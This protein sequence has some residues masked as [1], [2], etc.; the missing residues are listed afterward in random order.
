MYAQVNQ[1]ELLVARHKKQYQEI[2]AGMYKMPTEQ[3][4]THE[5]NQRTTPIGN[6]RRTI[7]RDQY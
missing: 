5:E 2:C 6:S 3:D 4:T 7:V 1:E